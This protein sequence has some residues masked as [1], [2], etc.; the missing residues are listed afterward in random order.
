[1]PNLFVAGSIA[2]SRLHPMVVDR[3]G[4]A[5]TQDMAFLV[6]DADGADR[7]I[8]DVLATI[9][10]ARVTIFC[11]GDRPR[12]NVADWPVHH[13]YPLAPAG[14]RAFFTAKDVEMAGIADY[15]LMVW[16]ARSTGTL[17]NV[18]ELLVRGR[19][20]VV[21]VNRDKAFHTIGDLPALE[22]LIA[23]MSA[24]ALDKAER[25]MGLRRR[26]NALRTE[27]FALSI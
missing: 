18:I 6:G 9:E 19:K 22:R 13:V 3:I 27:Q 4:H 8:Q 7:A 14:T 10:D 16:D 5:A 20:T 1:M 17:S 26:L 21:F 24:S 11:S 12:N 2:I 23:L 25:K 15:G